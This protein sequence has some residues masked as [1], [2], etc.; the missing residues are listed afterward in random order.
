MLGEKTI[1]SA[2]MVEGFWKADYWKPVQTGG[3]FDSEKIFPN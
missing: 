1:T 2:V 3:R